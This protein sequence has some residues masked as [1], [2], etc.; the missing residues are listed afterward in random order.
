MKSLQSLF[1]S[2]DYNIKRLNND[3]QGQLSVLKFSTNNSWVPNRSQVGRLPTGVSNQNSGF[4][5][6]YPIWSLN[7]RV[8]HFTCLIIRND[9]ME[10]SNVGPPMQ[11]LILAVRPLAILKYNE[12]KR[13]EIVV[14]WMKSRM[15]RYN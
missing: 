2:I 9:Q 8:T 6:E 14:N 7:D 1:D 13:F 15:K 5:L 11:S 10:Y 3:V 4:A 12:I